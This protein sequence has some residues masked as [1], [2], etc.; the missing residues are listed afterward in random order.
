MRTDMDYL[1]L[2]SYLLDKREQPTWRDGDR[3][4]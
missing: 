3:W 1:S 2:G 4:Q